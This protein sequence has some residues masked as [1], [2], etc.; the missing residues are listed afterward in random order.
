ML[1]LLLI[2]AAGA[3]GLACSGWGA[4]AGLQ[5]ACDRSGAVG[6]LRALVLAVIAN[7]SAFLISPKVGSPAQAAR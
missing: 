1:A 7:Q 5:L 4:A 2:S 6:L 3:F